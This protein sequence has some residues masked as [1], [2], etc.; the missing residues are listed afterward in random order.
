MSD[1]PT[2]FGD[3]PATSDSI[4]WDDRAS[5]H[6]AGDDSGLLAGATPLRRGTF[7]E[8]ANDLMAMPEEKRREY[9][10][11]KAGDR[12]YSAG[13]IAALIADRR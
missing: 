1:H 6:R 7:G 2:A 13:E 3:A 11:S 5:L 9:V 12:S 10:I 8:L 4:D